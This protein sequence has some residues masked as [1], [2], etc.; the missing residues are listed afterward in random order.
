[1]PIPK[2]KD[3]EDRNKFMS[4]CMSDPTMSKEYKD[5]KQ[6]VAVCISKATEGL[7]YVQAADFHLYYNEFGYTEE[8]DENNFYVPAEA[9]YEDWDDGEV[10]EWDWAASRPGLWENIRRKK[11]REGK[12]YKP[13]KTVKEGRPTQEQLKRAQSDVDAYADFLE[14]EEAEA[15]QRG[16]P[17]PN[18]PRKTPAPPKDRKK[19]SKKNKPDS[20]K[21]DKGKISFSKNTES[22]LREAVSKH[23]AK[24]KGPKATLGMLKAVYRR[25]A[26]AFSTSHAPK[27]SRDGWAMARVRAFLYLLRNGRPSNPN[28]KQDNDLL[29]SGH[30]RSSKGAEMSPKQKEAL[31]KNKD[32]KISKED[33]ELLRKGKAKFEYEDPK[34]GELFYFERQGIYKN[35][36]RFLV[37]RQKF[38]AEQLDYTESAEYQGRK[39]KLGKPFRTPGGPK[40]S[41]VYVKNE[42]GNVVKVNFGDPNM[43]IKKNIP[44]RRKNFRARHNCDNPGPRW[45]ARY[46]SCRAW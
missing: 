44:G 21:D 9:D 39:V 33:F 30:K 14:D 40:K 29:P 35:D 17:G 34:T 20:A 42:K 18:D 2:R 16:K 8:I 36:G 3:G 6:R 28:Y 1:M 11:E 38:Y 22:R 31:D 15:L 43:K 26:G 10:E 27:M 45:K 5:N 25:G 13:A 41:A 7:D 37:L 12:N 19:G 23:N 32:G 4:R 46:W 24:G